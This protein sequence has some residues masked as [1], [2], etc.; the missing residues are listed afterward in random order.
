MYICI[1]ID[2]FALFLFF[3]FF[4]IL[5]ISTFDALQVTLRTSPFFLF[6]YECMRLGPHSVGTYIHSTICVPNLPYIYIYV[7][8]SYLTFS[9]S[10][11]G[12]TVL[13]CLF[14]C[15]VCAWGC[16]STKCCHGLNQSWVDN[17]NSMLKYHIYHISYHFVSLP[18]KLNTRTLNLTIVI[19]IDIIPLITTKIFVK[20]YLKKTYSKMATSQVEQENQIRI[21]IEILLSR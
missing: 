8:S 19:V 20:N 12:G 18:I 15:S 13:Y 1:F 11:G 9:A 2:Y 21:E 16:V 3:S 14:G 5:L 7:S 10:V 6:F 4:E 17:E